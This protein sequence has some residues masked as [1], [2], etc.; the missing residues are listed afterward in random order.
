MQTYTFKNKYGYAKG[1]FKKDGTLWLN[2]LY[3]YSK[4]RGKGY[5]HTIVNELPRPI[6][7]YAYP[8]FNKSGKVRAYE[9]LIQYY[10]NIGF[11]MIDQAEPIM[12]LDM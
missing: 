6:E 2:E 4:Y 5:S 7:L 1:Y 10:K 8:L 11:V 12:R 3:V 9:S